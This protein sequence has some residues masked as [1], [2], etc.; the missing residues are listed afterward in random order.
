MDIITERAKPILQ[1]RHTDNAATPA[2]QHDYRRRARVTNHPH[3]ELNAVKSNHDRLIPIALNVR[4]QCDQAIQ[5]MGKQ[6]V[7]HL[8]IV[9][10]RH[11]LRA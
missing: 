9:D 3:I 7:E 10:S 5:H 11:A 2:M 8:G 4:A 1:R 6:P